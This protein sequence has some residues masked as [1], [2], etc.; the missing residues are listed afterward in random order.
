MQVNFNSSYNKPA[1]GMAVKFA[2]SGLRVIKLQTSKMPEKKYEKFYE[3]LNEIVARQEDNHD[4]D[5]LIRGGEHLD[6]LIVEVV[7]HGDNPVKISKYS[8][9]LFFPSGLKCLRKAEEK[10]N[11]VKDLNERLREYPLAT[12]KDYISG[13]VTEELEA[14]GANLD[15]DV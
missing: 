5:T 11:R 13:K 4:A 1:F 9:S 6:R 7:D 12:E 8:Q 3:E 14:D 15:L 2:P 10:A